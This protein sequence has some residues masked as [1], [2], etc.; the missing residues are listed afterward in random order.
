M[1]RYYAQHGLIGNPQTLCRLL[2]RAPNNLAH[3]VGSVIT[4]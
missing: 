3:F 1:F 2:G 4:A